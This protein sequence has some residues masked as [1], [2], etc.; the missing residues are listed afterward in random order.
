MHERLKANNDK[1][2]SLNNEIEQY[3]PDDEYKTEYNAVTEYEDNATRILAEL[4]SMSNST[5]VHSG[6]R[7][8]CPNSCSTTRWNMSQVAQANNSLF[9]WRLVQMGGIVG[10]V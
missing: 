8:G 5:I 3:I 9:P 4:L 6:A 2:R 10:T 7:N 1:L